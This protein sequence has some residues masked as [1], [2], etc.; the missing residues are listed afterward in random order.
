MPAV[1]GA[2]DR[3]ADPEEA[4]RLIGCLSLEDRAI[5][6]TAIYAG[7]RLGEL[8]ALGWDDIDLNARLIRVEWSWDKKVGRVRPKSSAGRRPAYASGPV[9]RSVGVRSRSVVRLRWPVAAVAAPLAV[10]K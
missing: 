7:L 4:E 10:L 1:E 5:W 3:V 2:R 8:Q 9:V 6:A